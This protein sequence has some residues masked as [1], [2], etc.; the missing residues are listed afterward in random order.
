MVSH[1]HPFTFQTLFS[2]LGPFQVSFYLLHWLCCLRNPVEHHT[3]SMAT[4]TMALTDR[5]PLG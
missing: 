4:R 1:Y 3:S 5:L 2:L